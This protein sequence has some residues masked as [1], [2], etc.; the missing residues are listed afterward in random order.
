MTIDH[1]EYEYGRFE[2]L[3]EVVWSAVRALAAISD[4]TAADHMAALR[5]KHI[6]KPAEM[7]R[8]A[9]MLTTAA[10]WI[11]ARVETTTK[12]LMSRR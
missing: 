4:V 10:G 6:D 3:L 7:V 1:D 2:R 9:A 11:Q 12:A 8:Y 5:A